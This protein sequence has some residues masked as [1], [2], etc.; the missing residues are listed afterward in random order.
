MRLIQGLK[1][2]EE[3]SK[4]LMLYLET[5][6]KGIAVIV[7]VLGVVPFLLYVYVYVI[8]RAIIAAITVYLKSSKT[9]KQ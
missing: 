5:F 7:I 4:V 3:I 6:F 2:E 1:L 9:K 8:T